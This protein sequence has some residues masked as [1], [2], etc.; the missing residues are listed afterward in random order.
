MDYGTFR[1]QSRK[2]GLSRTEKNGNA[3]S[4]GGKSQLTMKNTKVEMIAPKF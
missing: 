3:P 2:A 1:R 4:Q